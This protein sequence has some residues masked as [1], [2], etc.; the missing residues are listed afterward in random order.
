V[1]LRA[2]RSITKTKSVSGNFIVKT[3]ICKSINL[4]RLASPDSSADENKTSMPEIVQSNNLSDPASP[5]ATHTS[6]SK[7]IGMQMTPNPLIKNSFASP[8]K[9][10]V[11][12]NNNIHITPAADKSS[13]A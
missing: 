10:G 4:N 3:T 11:G 9:L 2:A 12:N 13:G 1:F 8:V 5:L 6:P 7:M